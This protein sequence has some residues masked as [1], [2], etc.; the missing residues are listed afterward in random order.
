MTS[1]EE[2]REARLN[3]LEL[4]K[5]AGINAY[6]ANSNQEV[7]CAK[8]TEDYEFLSLK[9]ALSLVG[10]IM[11]L[12]A[13][14]K[15]IFINIDD[16]TGTFQALLKSGE[17]LETD[18]FDLFLNTF[19]IGDFVEVR[20]TL[21]LTKSEQKTVLVEEFKMLSKSLRPLPEKWHGLTDTEERFRKRYLDLISSPE[22]KARFVLRSRLVSEIRSM[23]DEAGYLEVETPA[24][25]A[26]YGGASAEPF[27]THHNALDSD[28]Y[29]R[30]SDELY[31]KRLLAGGFPKVY[32]IARD[33]RNEG[34]DHTHNPEFTML[35]FYEAYSNAELQRGFVEKMMK[36]LVERLFST[37]SITWN[38]Q[39]I[40]FAPKFEVITYFDV[41][42]KYVGIENP[43]SATIND[44]KDR[45][46]QLGV[47]VSPTDS[48]YKIMDNMYKKAARP[49]LIQPTFII[50]YPE[51]YLP[52]AKKK[53]GEDGI[54]EAFQLVIGGTELV[55]AFSELNDPIDQRAR[56]VSQAEIMKAGDKEAQ[57]LDEDFIEA[58]EHGIPPAGGV[59]I[60]IDRLTMLLTNTDN[61]KE[62]I[63]FPTLKA[64]G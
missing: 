34:I 18:K 22:V 8:A 50:D 35:E 49:Q 21:F 27:V 13:Q 64:R 52:L 31:L 42:K 62:V 32:E 53:E 3:K 19:D 36:R 9:G 5:E 6:P 43:R 1:I 15:I 57:I 46:A 25:Q 41:L 59:G 33:F 38:E 54:V 55:K 40:D 56:F 60:G 44:L 63:L 47:P 37:L 2:I 51:N 24:L 28:L 7:T 20:G 17:P 39:M 48:Y 14:G 45:A 23:L 10:R 4:L 58:M 12:R 11:S 16:G 30:I 29:L 61:I 26:V